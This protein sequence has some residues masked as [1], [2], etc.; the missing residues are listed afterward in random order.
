MSP[1]EQQKLKDIVEKTHAKGRRLRFWATPENTDLWR[2]LRAAGVDLIG[3]DDLKKLS[4][5]LRQD[6]EKETPE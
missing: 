3:T 2:T 1:A 6:A 4:N 5:F